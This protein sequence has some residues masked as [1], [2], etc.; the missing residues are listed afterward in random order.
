M[1]RVGHLPPFGDPLADAASTGAIVLHHMFN[2]KVIL[3]PDNTVVKTGKRIALGEAVA[4]RTAV[5]AGIPAPRVHEVKELPDDVGLIR[6]EY[7]HGET[8]DRMWP[9]MSVEDKKGVARQLREILAAMRVLTP[10]PDL[11]GACDGTEIRDTRLH[12]TYHNP[13]CRNEQD[14]NDFLLSNLFDTVPSP[15]KAAFARRLQT[16]HRIVFTHCDLAP[17]NIIVDGGKIVGLIDWEDS[18]WYPEYWE[19]VKFFQRPAP[20]DWKEYAAEIFPE[21]Y[22]DQ[23]VDYVAISKWQNS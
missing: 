19:Y 21:T 12:F 3:Y 4:L 8:L 22:P 1:S 6:M 11:I 7:L 20:K 5:D 23:L 9:D 17:R 2:R 16:H 18:G 14:F 15:L 10:P 13:V